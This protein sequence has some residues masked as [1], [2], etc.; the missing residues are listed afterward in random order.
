[1]NSV[2]MGKQC[3]RMSGRHRGTN[4]DF[5]FQRAPLIPLSTARLN[6][7]ALTFAHATAVFAYASDPEISR[8]VAWPR[9]ESL[10]DSRRFVAR[11]MIGY[12]VGDHYEWGLLRRCDQ[13]FLGTCGFGEIDRACG[14]GEIGYVLAQ[15]YWGQ[16]YA[17]EAAAAV[18]QFGFVQLGL[19]LIEAQ[20]FAENVASLRVMAKLGLR[21]RET[22]P[23]SKDPGE[24]R[25]VRVLQLERQ[26]W[27]GIKRA[28]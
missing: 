6:L 5:L 25:P 23:I 4:P 24:S 14:V 18:L 1:M 12:A 21:Y 17:T 9:H 26:Q 10:E 7:V 2:A 3:L 16:G 8:L 28:T 22:R 11:S 27:A 20:A 15:P 13:A 19:R